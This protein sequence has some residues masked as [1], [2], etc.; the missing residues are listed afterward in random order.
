MNYSY[1]TD[2]SFAKFVLFTPVQQFST[3]PGNDF[4]SIIWNRGEDS[5]FTVDGIAFTLKSNAVLTLTPAHH[6]N[7]EQPNDA[8]VIIRF[9]ESFYCVEQHDK[10]V[11]C[12]GYIFYGSANIITISLDDE[13][14][15]RFGI[16]LDMLAEEFENKDNIQG[17]M[18]TILLKRL[19]IKCTRLARIQQ[20]GEKNKHSNHPVIR[21]FNVLVE[22]HFKTEHT[23]GFYAQQLSITAKSL[24]NLLSAAKLLSPIAIIHNRLLTEA[25]RQLLFSDKPVKQICHELNFTDIQTF[26]RFFKARQ[27]VSPLHFKKSKKDNS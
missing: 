14:Q 7:I 18:L 10:D 3:S 21:Q 12:I 16:L 6:F 19:I 11:S 27:G 26:S 24:S 5:L 15:K 1:A 9:N 23:V 17:E 22:I 4:Y 2:L 8:L 20:Y 25:R 13:E